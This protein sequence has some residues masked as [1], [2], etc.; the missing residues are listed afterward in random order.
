M[1]KLLQK[2]FKKSKKEPSEVEKYRKWSNLCCELYQHANLQVKP[3]WLHG[4]ISDGYSAESFC[5]GFETDKGHMEFEYGYHWEGSNY[6]N[7]YYCYSFIEF[8]KDECKITVLK[9]D[10]SDIQKYVDLVNKTFIK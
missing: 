8:Y 9:D 4:M 1:K 5:V 6:K 10:L 7:G 3:T 2:I